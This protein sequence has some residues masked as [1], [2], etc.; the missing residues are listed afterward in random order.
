MDDY[1]T[2]EMAAS[3]EVGFSCMRFEWFNMTE[4]EGQSSIV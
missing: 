3:T 1:L 2:T 4:P